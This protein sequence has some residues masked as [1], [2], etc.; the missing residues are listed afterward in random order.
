LTFYLNSATIA[1]YEFEPLKRRLSVK[2]KAETI[3]IKREIAKGRIEPGTRHGS[4]PHRKKN[5]YT[6][7]GKQPRGEE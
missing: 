3:R 7:K 6:R 4:Y 2:I 5:K 1:K